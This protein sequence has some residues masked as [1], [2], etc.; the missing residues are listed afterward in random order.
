[1]STDALISFEFVMPFWGDARQFREA[2][3]SIRAQ[4]D[5]NWTLTVIDDAYPDTAPGAWLTGLSDPRI[6][7]RR[8]PVNLGINRNFQAALDAATADWVVIP[9]C[10]DRLHPGYLTLMRE[11]ARRH[12]EAGLLHPGVR[13][14]G[15]AGTPISTLVDRSKSLYRGR[16]RGEV[17][18]ADERFATS[19]TRGNWMYFPAIAWRRELAARIG[20]QPGLEVAQDLGLALDVAVSG[21]H[22]VYH[23]HVVFDYRRHDASVSSALAVDGSRFAEEQRF[24][25]AWA[26]RFHALEWNHAARAARIHLSSRINAASRI[27]AALR[28]R[29]WRGLGLIAR[30]LLGLSITS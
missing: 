11:L 25:R 3:E 15:D 26:R 1:L 27:P 4:D 6:R 12:P 21:G 16:M 30:H 10:D 23:D 5:P 18:L 7:Y 2:V 19:I 13:V 28:Q 20:F 29:E 17:E 8:N 9:G 22:L 14:I 24:F